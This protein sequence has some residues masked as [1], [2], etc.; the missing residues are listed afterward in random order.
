MSFNAKTTTMSSIRKVRVAGS[1]ALLVR[2]EETDPHTK[3]HIDGSGTDA[4]YNDTENSGVILFEGRCL[5]SPQKRSP[6]DGLQTAT[7]RSIVLCAVLLAIVG[8]LA[9]SLMVRCRTV[10]LTRYLSPRSVLLPRHRIDWHFIHIGPARELPPDVQEQRLRLEGRRRA[11]AQ[12]GY[13]GT[14][15]LVW[16]LGDRVD[17]QGRRDVEAGDELPA[18]SSHKS[19]PPYSGEGIVEHHEHIHETI[20]SDPVIR[21]QELSGPGALSQPD[22]SAEAPTIPRPALLRFWGP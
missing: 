7:V 11:H 4:S 13:Y 3:G 10:R 12:N 20:P 5:C 8:L 6:A 18:Y 2:A 14:G 22:S 21:P 9:F 16:V 19:P 17:T 1:M 15:G